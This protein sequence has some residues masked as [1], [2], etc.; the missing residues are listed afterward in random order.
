[1]LVNEKNINKSIK[2]INFLIESYL[3]HYAPTISIE[4]KKSLNLTN[5]GK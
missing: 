2:E 3:I 5:E 4:I 1:M